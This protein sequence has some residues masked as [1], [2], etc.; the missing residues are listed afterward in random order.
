HIMIARSGTRTVI[1][2]LSE[3]RVHPALDEIGFCAFLSEVRE[4]GRPQDQ[5]SAE[6]PILVTMAGVILSGFGR[7]RFRDRTLLRLLPVLAAKII[8]AWVRAKFG[9]D[10]GVIAIPHTFNSK[11]D[12]NAHVHVM[13]TAGGLEASGRWRSSVY[14]DVDALT[15]YWRKGVIR[16]LRA[17]LR[18][19]AALPSQHGEQI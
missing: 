11:L 6:E 9:L 7:W 8:E 10:I 3:L 15:H 12:F 19:G 13:I 4:A 5:M 14:L 17:N 1:H 16:L 18:V 2:L